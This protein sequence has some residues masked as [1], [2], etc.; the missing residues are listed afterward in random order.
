VE[1]TSPV[2]FVEYIRT[3]IF[4]AIG[5]MQVTLGEQKHGASLICLLWQA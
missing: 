2:Q 3:Q 4:H 5:V 1:S